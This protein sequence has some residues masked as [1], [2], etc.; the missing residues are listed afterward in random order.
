MDFK[1]CFLQF[2]KDMIHSSNRY[3]VNDRNRD[4][5]LVIIPLK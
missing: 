3:T 2:N 1:Q 5:F 4:V